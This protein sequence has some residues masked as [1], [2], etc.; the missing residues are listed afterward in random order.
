M[1][2]NVTDTQNILPQNNKSTPPIGKI[3]PVICKNS[4]NPEP[5]KEKENDY[6]FMFVDST[7]SNGSSHLQRPFV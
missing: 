2:M 5:I 3:R 4:L 6:N 1:R 7:A